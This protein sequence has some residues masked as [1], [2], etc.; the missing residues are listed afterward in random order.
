DDPPDWLS[1]TARE[2]ESLRAWCLRLGVREVH[3]S[4]DAVDLD[5]NVFQTV[6]STDANPTH[7][8]ITCALRKLETRQVEE[9]EAKRDRPGEATKS[10]RARFRPRRDRPR[11][12]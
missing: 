2:I 10:L 4:G 11:G 3:L 8:A 5:N 12:E 6:E 9:A 7:D 1:A